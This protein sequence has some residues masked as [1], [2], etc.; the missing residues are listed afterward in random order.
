[1]RLSLSRRLDW[2]LA[3]AIIVATACGGGTPIA[4]HS[5]SPVAGALNEGLIAY[6][7]DKGVGVLDPTSGKS[8]IVAPLPAGAAFRVSGPVWAPAPGVAYP[9]LYFTIHDDRPAERRTTPPGVIPYDWLFRADPFTGVI[10]PLAASADLQSEGPFGLAANARY[11]ALTVGCCANYEVDALDVT[12]PSAGLKVLAKP[13]TQAALFTE[14]AAPGPD[15]LIAVRAFGTGAWY[16]LNASAAVLNPFPLSL[17]PEDGPIAISSDGT[18]AAI[19][20]PDQGP[21]IEPINV[22]T[23]VASPS[24]VTS[25]TAAATAAPA[26]ASPAPSAAPRHVNSKLPHADG[27]AWSPD[28]KKLGL[29]VNGGIEIYSSSGADGAAPVARYLT[30]GNVIDI[31]WSAPMPGQ[32]LALV[33]PNAG[34]QS[35]V[36]ALL[37]ATKLPAAADTAANRPLTKV[38]LWQFDSTRSS[39]IATI[40]DATPAILQQYPPLAAGVNLHHWAPSNFWQLLGGCF[41]YRV[42]ITGSVP[43]TASTVGL[44]SN[45]ACNAPI[46]TPTPSPSPS[47]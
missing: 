34:P 15:G 35:F 28:A 17:G 4:T 21:V 45:I 25:G 20:L 1:V 9:V 19:S 16:W 30:G 2:V 40:A 33:K 22:A 36:D 31:D 12:R 8:T 37:E 11:L 38:Y 41:R 43:P 29:A 32:S 39:P 5:P 47:K 3:L 14:G 44:A 46:V 18:L 26:H 27:L 13:P 10:E 42:V 7:S 23:P 6:L 24:P